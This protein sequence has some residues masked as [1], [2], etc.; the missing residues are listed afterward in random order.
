[1]DI[2]YIIGSGPSG[3]A[4]ALGWLDRQNVR[5]VMLD[6]GNELEPDLLKKRERL[7]QPI[8]KAN[9][10][11][12]WETQNYLSKHIFG[13][14]YPYEFDY[15]D[16][17]ISNAIM[18]AS[19]A[20]GGLSNIWG[21]SLMSYRKEDLHDWPIQDFTPY[22][23][24]ILKI[25]PISTCF[26]DDF[27]SWPLTNSSANYIPS[28]QALHLWKKYQNHKYILN[29]N[30]I[31]AGGS[32]LAIY[33]NQCTYCNECMQGCLQDAIYSTRHTLSILK[34]N[35]SFI[36]Q[37]NVCV[38]KIIEH[39]NTV[40]IQAMDTQTKTPLQLTGKRVFLATGV[41]LSAKIL[42]RSFPELINKII[43]R[44][45]Q[46]FILP[47]LMWHRIKNLKNQPA[48]S[49]SQL[50]YEILNPHLTNESLHLQL[51]TY[52]PIFEMFFNRFGFLKNRLRF[53]IERMVVLQ[54]YLPSSLSGK[55]SLT[56]SQNKIKILGERQQNSF[57]LL[58]KIK[59]LINQHAF[60]LGLI[61]LQA[62]MSL[63]GSGNHYG[64]SFPMKINPQAPNETDLF[65]RPLN[66]K[67]V[68][69]VDASIFPSIPAQS[70]TLTVM[71]NA[72]R[73]ANT[74]LGEKAC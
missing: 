42:M 70:I 28:P 71:A 17:E 8:L 15:Q 11:P 39:G 26:Q 21:G 25:L 56:I 35:P 64:S 47:S 43:I 9:R 59:K 37:K 36:Y 68:H 12:P 13:S 33:Q 34:K 23:Q 67:R 3:I 53:F 41:L 20:T 31:T 30:G 16:I 61:P 54:G 22:Y 48:H 52:M 18:T 72:Y 74:C 7:G 69:L 5:V 46:R 38:E 27:S 45:S 29:K 1:M 14:I 66:L 55:I 6:V 2:V 4:C 50:Y 62:K 49:L 32:R 60:F 51:Y 57:I 40:E 58:K 44:D 19:F 73:I 63:I 24:K 10:L 65:G